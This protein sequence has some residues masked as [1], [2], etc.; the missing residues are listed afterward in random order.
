[1]WQAAMVNLNEQLHIENHELGLPDGH[2]GVP[3]SI[4]CDRLEGS[5]AS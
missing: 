1:M 2:P 5:S 4:V 3:V